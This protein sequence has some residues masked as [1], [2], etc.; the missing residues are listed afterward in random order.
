M[1]LTTESLRPYVGGQME[2]QNQVEEYFFR[3]EI[4]R[5]GV[6]DGSLNV[7]FS[8]LAKGEGYSRDC[9]IP[10]RW[11]REEPKDYTASLEMY[12]VSDIGS[13]PDSQ[14]SRICLQS[15]FTNELVVLFPKGGSR[16]DPSNVQGLDVSKLSEASS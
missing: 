1:K 9:P 14:G 7:G 5:I 3:G 10:D 12:S 4:S 15:S 13:S 6:D 2:I 16:L 11:V 8:W